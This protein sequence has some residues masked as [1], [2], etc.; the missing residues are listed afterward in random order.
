M[1]CTVYYS[2]LRVKKLIITENGHKHR[3][4]LYSPYIADAKK[5]LRQNHQLIS[6]GHSAT[7]NAFLLILHPKLAAPFIWPICLMRKSYGSRRL[8]GSCFMLILTSR[9]EDFWTGSK[10]KLNIDTNRVPR[11]FGVSKRASE[12]RNLWVEPD[13]TSEQW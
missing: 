9:R 10:A 3:F 8:P 6:I 11:W 4:A 2:N 1:Q 13:K 5:N 12:P 7:Q